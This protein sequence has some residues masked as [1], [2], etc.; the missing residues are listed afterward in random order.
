MIERR[1]VVIPVFKSRLGDRQPVF[2]VFLSFF[3]RMPGYNL[4]IDHDRFLPN[5]FQII[6][7][8]SL[9]YSTL[10]SLSH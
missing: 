5:P 8:A 9:F 4:K 1:A 6:I 2:V 10:Y 3:R 7:N